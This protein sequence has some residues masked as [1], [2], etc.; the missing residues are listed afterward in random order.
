MTAILKSIGW[1]VITFF[2]AGLFVLTAEY[3]SFQTDLRFLKEKQDLIDNPVWM[4]AFYVH[5]SSAMFVLLVGPFQFL[6]KLRNRNL[7]VHRILGKIY[8]YGIFLLAAPSGLV[9]ALYAEGG[10]WSEVAFT[11]LSILWFGTTFMAVRTVLKKDIVGHQKWMIRSFAVTFA[12]VT[13]RLMVAIF[14]LFIS[15]DQFIIVSTA[16]LCWVINMM[17]AEIMIWYKFER[18]KISAKAA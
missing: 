9:M 2:A 16:W 3:L 6:E 4:T 12:A 5:I 1:L 18:N 13:L 10:F 8:V 15:D 11:M 7:K 17:V 14:S